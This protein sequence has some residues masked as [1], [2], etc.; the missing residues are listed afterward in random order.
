V[1]AY[2]LLKWW[3]F[4]LLKLLRKLHLPSSSSSSPWGLSS[5]INHYVELSFIGTACWKIEMIKTMCNL[6]RDDRLIVF[7]RW[8]D[9]QGQNYFLRKASETWEHG[10]KVVGLKLN[11]S[12]QPWNVQ[13]PGTV[14]CRKFLISF[15]IWSPVQ[16]KTV[17]KV[18]KNK[19]VNTD[20]N[21]ILLNQTLERNARYILSPLRCL[22]QTANEQHLFRHAFLKNAKLLTTWTKWQSFYLLMFRLKSTLWPSSHYF[23]L[24]LLCQTP[25]NKSESLN[26]KRKGS[27]STNN[28]EILF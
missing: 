10:S 20:I 11:A 16:V 15:W 4:Y 1:V 9:S 23:F 2:I 19:S 6:P 26:V 17:R 5:I 7:V 14:C 12:E 18:C 22:K 27:E 8:G 21:T 13:I 28:E 24:P 25:V 3:S